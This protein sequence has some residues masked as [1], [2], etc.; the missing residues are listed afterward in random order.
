PAQPVAEPSAPPWHPTS[1]ESELEAPAAAGPTG[2]SVVDAG[3]KESG[4]AAAAAGTPTPAAKG[5]WEVVGQAP[6]A[7]KILEEKKPSAAVGAIQ[8]AVLVVG[9]VMILIGCLV[10]IANVRTG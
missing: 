10:M 2:W 3:G 5:G 9:L 6:E 4:M 1:P 7:E 8:Y